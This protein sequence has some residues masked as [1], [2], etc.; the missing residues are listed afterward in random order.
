MNQH[1]QTRQRSSGFTLIEILVA[2]VVLAIGVLGVAALQTKSLSQGQGTEQ[3][4]QAWA[5]AYD[6]ADRM[7]ANPDAAY[8]GNYEID[9]LAVITNTTSC[10]AAAPCLSQP[11]ANADKYAWY[12]LVKNAFPAGF[13]VRVYCTDGAHCANTQNI[14]P[15]QTINIVVYWNQEKNANESQASITTNMLHCG[16]DPSNYDPIAHNDL[17][18]VTLSVQP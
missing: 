12:T 18:C 10:T 7:H 3:A 15:P 13:A 8:F 16:F 14:G 4:T 17:P 6:Y 5:L 9:P 2:I 1:I 11:L